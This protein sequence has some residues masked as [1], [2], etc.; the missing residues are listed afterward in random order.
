MYIHKNGVGVRVNMDSLFFDHALLPEGW[1]RDVR[2]DLGADGLI[3]TVAPGAKRPASGTSGR[4]AVPGMANLHS[5]AFQRAMAGLGE[6]RGDGD[7]SFW[8]WRE[9]MYR[10]LARLRP[11]DLNAVAAQLY[12]EMLEAGF[13]AVGEFHYVHRQTDG[14]AY[15]DPAQLSLEIIEAARATGIGLT[16]LPVFYAQGGFNAA[17]VIGGQL[18]FANDPDSFADLVERCGHAT[19]AD[20]RTRL[21]VAPHS[22][23][24]VTAENLTQ[25]VQAASSG[26]IHIHMAEQTREVEDCLAALD[27]RPV[28]WLLANHDVDQRWCL[29]H[30]THMQPVET[31]ALARSGAVAGLCPITEA[32]LGDGIFDGVRYAENGG[33]WGIGSDSHIRIDVAEEL[34]SLE[35]SQR[36]RD[37]ARGRLVGASQANGRA[38]FDTALAG[39]ARAIDQ[40]MG[41]IAP[42]AWCDLVSLDA[43]H[44]ALIGKKDDDWLN[45]WIFSGDPSC[46]RDVWA[47]GRHVVVDGVHL[48]RAAIRAKFAKAMEHLLA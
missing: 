25:V 39:G 1:A 31:G 48:E 9:T 27:A 38:L 15:D 22:L 19:K 2:I 21:G 4:I 8:T 10:F 40:P 33:R 11:E 24:A 16:L 14:A 35:Y 34:R 41:A 30:A 6:W 32:N 7:D 20:P 29:I 36:L 47:A 26:P 18:R 5:H 37:R 3:A 12:C 28:E 42:G 45:G 46:V 44:P 43:D 13:T 23:R 17:P